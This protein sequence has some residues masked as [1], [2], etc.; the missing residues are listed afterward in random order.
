[1]RRL[2]SPELNPLDYYVHL[3][4]LQALSKTEDINELKEMLQMMV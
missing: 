3:G 1:M 2:N 4:L